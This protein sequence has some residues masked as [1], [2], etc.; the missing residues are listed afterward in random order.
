MLSYSF[1]SNTEITGENLMLKGAFWTVGED[2]LSYPVEI[3]TQP[4]PSH[5]DV[6]KL[7][8]GEHKRKPWNYFPR[9]RV[10]IRNDKAIIFANP[11]CFLYK[12]LENKIRNNFELGNVQIIYKADNS[13]HYQYKM[14]Y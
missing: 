7:V 13:R 9:G 4:N 8:C 3:P 12:D 10:E 5:K 14:N 1:K 2:I 6:W 11:D